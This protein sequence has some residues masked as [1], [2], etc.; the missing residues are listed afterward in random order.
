[1]RRTLLALAISV[2][3]AI[4]TV[5]PASALDTSI[6][7]K[8]TDGTSVPLVVDANTL[9]A[10]TAAV[11]AMLDYPAG[12]S[13]SIIQNPLG[14]TFGHIALAS[15]GTSP[16]IVG[17]GR[18]QAPFFCEPT[19]HPLDGAEVA[20]VPGT[21]AYEPINWSPLHE[22]AGLVWVNIAV[23]VHRADDGTFFGTLNET[24]P[25]QTTADCGLINERHFTS[26]PTCLKTSGDATTPRNAVVTSPVTQTSG[27]AFPGAGPSDV[28]HFSFVDNGNPSEGT[29]FL[30]GPPAPGQDDSNCPTFGTPPTALAFS[31][32]NGNISIR[33]AQP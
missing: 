32:A 12:L 33:N 1:M 10:L 29:D 6:T 14:V 18:W 20:K 26:R 2:G 23:N 27:G 16:F 15:P 3:L 24:I 8:C 28:V 7:L 11:Q 5:A 9:I 25:N 21:W 19:P 30:K 22:Q 13:C 4:G 31:L 17:G